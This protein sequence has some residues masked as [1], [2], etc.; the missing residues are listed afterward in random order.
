MDSIT[1]TEAI[2]FDMDGVLVDVSQSYHY[3]I[4]STAEFFTG[5]EI[6]FSEIIEYKNKGG[7]NNDWECTHAIISG[8]D[9]DVILWEVMDKFQ[10]LYLGKNFDGLILNET[11]L[12]KGDILETLFHQFKLGIVTGRPKDEAEYVLERYDTSDFFQVLITLDDTP[13][14]KRKP[15]PFGIKKALQKLNTKNAIYLGDSIDD[16]KAASSAKIF[17]VGILTPETQN[18]KQI[19]L[20]KK[21]GAVEVLNS[22]NDVL[23]LYS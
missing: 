3:A 6:Q 15:E 9:I 1:E 12:L 11:W 22:A 21:W 4:K 19:D 2:L 8:Y 17:P 20:L 5:E 13:P 18:P 14:G 7:F 16:M 10:E 23:E